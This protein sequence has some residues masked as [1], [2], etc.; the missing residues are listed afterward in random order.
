MSQRD[1]YYWG[2]MLRSVSGFEIYRKVYRDVITPGP[3]GR[4]ADAARRHAALSAGLHG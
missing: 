4:A 2:A 1:F 3:H